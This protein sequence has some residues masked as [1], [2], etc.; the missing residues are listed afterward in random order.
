MNRKSFLT[1]LFVVV[2]SLTNAATII[3]PSDTIHFDTT[4]GTYSINGGNNVN[5]SIS[6]TVAT[7]TFDGLDI[8]SGATVTV[9][10]VNAIE[11]L[12]TADMSIASD[13]DVSGADAGGATAGAAAIGGWAG[14]D[15]ATSSTA[16]LAGS[17]PGAGGAGDDQWES[18]GGAG[19]GGAG[20]QGGRLT[21]GGG[22]GGASYGD[23]S[24]TTLQGGSGGG[25]G[26]GGGS[27]GG[28]GGAGGGAI[29]LG[30]VNVTIDATITAAG[31]DGYGS[32][33]TYRT[34]AGGSGGAIA[35]DAA[36][37]VT[38]SALGLLD[39][40]GGFGGD[41][42]YESACGGGGGGGRIYIDAASLTLDGVTQSQGVLPQSANLTAA[43]GLHG[44]GPVDPD[45]QGEDGVQGSI[46]YGDPASS[47]ITLYVATDGSDSNPG[48]ISQPFA[49]IERARDEIRNQKN[50]LGGLPATGAEVNIR[51]GIYNIAST[52]AFDSSDSGESGK[53]VVYQSYPG[54]EAILAGG[55]T[56]DPAWF[57]PVTNQTILDRIVNAS[58]KPN[59]L[60]CDLAG[61]G[62][63][64]YGQLD[65]HGFQC[66]QSS[67]P[68]ELYVD[69]RA[70]TLARW[71][72][73]G[74]GFETID[75]VISAG[76]TGSTSAT[77]GGTFSYTYTRPDNWSQ[78]NDVWIAG[79]LSKDWAYTYNKVASFNTAQQQIDLQYS[80]YYGLS[81]GSSFYW[82]E[83]LLEEIDAPGEYFIDRGTGIL[84]LLPPA[85]G[86]GGSDI[87][88]SSLETAMF[89]MTGTDYVTFKDITFDTSRSDMLV[90]TSVDNN[91]IDN[92]EIRN[93]GGDGVNIDGFNN[94][95]LGSYIHHI[96]EDAVIL[97]GGDTEAL[98]SVGNN[99]VENCFIKD[100]AYFEKGYS[101]AVKLYGVG[102]VVR[103]NII[104]DAPHF[105]V[106]IRGNDHLIELT[107][108]YDV[109]RLFKDGGVFYGYLGSSPQQRGT[110]I[111][112]NYI[113]DI[114]GPGRV[115]VYGDESTF[116][117]TIEQNVFYNLPEIYPAVGSNGP[118]YFLTNNN[119]FI[120]CANT[121]S[122]SFYLNT[123]GASKLSSY[124]T[125]WSNASSTYSFNNPS[126][127]HRQWYPELQYFDGE[128]KVWVDTCTF[129]SNFVW[130]P[131]VARV[132]S[133]AYDVREYDG[134]TR[135]QALAY[136]QASDNWIA[137]NN[138]G[139][140]DAAKGD[141]SLTASGLTTM[142]ANITNFIEIPFDQIGPAPDAIAPDAPTNLIA[143]SAT[144]VVDLDWSD[145]SEPDVDYYNIYRSTTSGSGYSQIA[146]N[147]K[148]SNY[149]DATTVIG[150]TYYYVLTAA[151][152]SG[153]ESAYS[154]EA[155]ATPLG[156]TVVYSGDTLAFNTTNATYSYNNGADELGTLVN[157][158]AVFD[159]PSLDIQAGST[160]TI[161]GSN[162]IRITS[163]G[164][165][166][167]SSPLDV[168]AA[169]GTSGTA[170]QA[171]LGGWAGGN[172][173]A[174]GLAGDPGQ[175]PGGGLA[176]D[177]QWES[178]G[179]GGYGGPGGQ[180]G[181]ITQGGGL[182]G[183][184]YGDET[185]T[186]F[187]GGSGGGGGG[188][189]GNT[190]GG[191]G[192]GGGA[193]EILAANI[194]VNSNIYAVGGDGH[195]DATTYRSGSAGS[196]GAIVLDAVNSIVV[197]SAAL[198]SAA[199]GDGGD[200]DREGSCGG[201]GGG[202]R[203]ALNASLLTIAGSAQSA[204]Y[205]TSSPQVTAVG[206][207]GGV[208]PIDTDRHGLDGSE[209]TIYFTLGAP[210]TTPPAL[211]TGLAAVSGDGSVSLDWDDNAEP[212]L[213][214]YTV[215]R[216]TTSGSGYAAIVTG[217]A[218]S[219]YVDNAAVNGTTYYYVVT[220]VDTSTNES[221]YSNE[222]SAT[223]I[224]APPTAP[225]GLVANAGDSTVSLDWDDNGESDLAS[226]TV[227]RSTTSGSGYV[228]IATEIATSDYADNT[229]VN[230]TAYY[231]VVTAVDAGSN[232]SG[233]SNEESAT[234]DV[235]PP[236]Q[237]FA[238]ADI[239]VLG[240]VSGSY[241]DTDS[242]D[243]VYESITEIESGGKP[244]NRYDY[245]EQKWTINVTGG[246]TVTFYV[247]AYKT[248]SSDND[249]FVFAYSTDDSSYTNMVTVT[250]T[251]D[252][253]SAQSF[254]L[255]ASTSG[256]IYIR[257]LDTDNTAGNRTF[258]TIYIDQMYI[259]SASGGGGP[260]IDPPT[261]NPAAFAVLPS[262]ESDTAIS[263]TATTGTDVS[264]PVE[265]YFD[266]T[267]GNL[268]GT[269]SGWQTSPSYTDTGL[270]PSTQYTYTVQMRDALANTGTASTPANATTQGA[271]TPTD[272]HV[273]SIIPD[274]QACGGPNKNGLV[275]VT[276]LD[277][278]G[279]PVVGATVTGTFTGDYSESQNAVT[280][281]SGVAVIVTSGCIKRP[282][283]GF[284]VDN[285]TGSLPYNSNDN[286]EFCS[287][288]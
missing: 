232:E 71:P 210:D 70:M 170:G 79:I 87:V 11:L 287:S 45:R 195:Y 164:D 248:T 240:T 225:T 249:D 25:G 213:A 156:L 108:F 6:G 134:K 241:A 141:F 220:A 181:R 84:Y 257:V 3:G 243:N 144:S 169:A 95:V 273:N 194:T 16:G 20:G 150:T 21:Q 38:I 260:D 147:V 101:N 201:G 283:Y 122:L 49:T 154:N 284:C 75:S 251:S 126:S 155:S 160:I 9:S 237:D 33:T 230:G 99:L 163:A 278:C 78:A 282:A 212:D 272:C 80:E 61:N 58:A 271:C 265:Y 56:L 196:G 227:Y 199:G 53:Q 14:G 116:G 209:G 207:L 24:I 158:I 48:T 137:T 60:Q 86:I 105:A 59:L 239:N 231:Y 31:G 68:M 205:L 138:P 10:G 276:I 23:T 162:A 85:G 72:N 15:G 74:D 203:I 244:A 171:A 73:D 39:A 128:D 67:P 189:G 221:G 218:T 12:S 277:D 255:P 256:T 57:S 44:N 88:V 197:D 54:E 186:T 94:S 18:G 100:F 198:V 266:E 253:D 19:Y 132:H 103:K 117:W 165:F 129:Q 269:D 175:G 235:T 63:T 29:K 32:A 148:S 64:N 219:D 107:E 46:V 83:N 264:G 96:G 285:V 118:N 191:G 110:L 179:G 114:Y 111:Y 166:I 133:E 229:V 247:E 130:N 215:Y 263:M 250:K 5:G 98:S 223:P 90:G 76:P 224:D 267:S 97:D 217:V 22:A 13:I 109:L 28:G 228:S 246:S 146:T 52:I 62:I 172:G 69:G 91:V 139:F 236:T 102:Q 268:G 77:P 187:Q 26:G 120:D 226:Y 36:G 258:D 89:T 184:A 281:S 113:H 173:G 81:A 192:A 112:Q 17:G 66:A 7:Y 115:G 168:S 40:S 143:S 35:I 259:E 245:L 252:D 261:P 145:N 190:G 188:G 51:G 140:V 149:S 193:I 177:D 30:A 159:F 222:D 270:S 185:V 216:S 176:G 151:D 37:V 288:Y 142:Q 34:G 4:A 65:R 136:I 106:T 135:T 104:H 153:N 206:G 200:N 274:V 204:G 275:T 121:F 157:N 279:S 180:G 119:Y 152:L 55:M 238:N 242:S 280:D 161:S 124:Q 125:D 208:G 262:A 8:Q 43:A 1:I 286:L 93:F 178:G 27:D 2:F 47:E 183:L 167:V 50:I 202:G 182:G 131:N 92:C 234:P 41:T 214:S 254:A 82:F 123:W 211:P 174:T 233:Y 127:P 42:S